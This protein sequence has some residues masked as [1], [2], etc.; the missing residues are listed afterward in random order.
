MKTKQRDYRPV[1]KGLPG[2]LT[3]MWPAC[4]IRS[5]DLPH[6][7]LKKAGLGFW[8]HG[9]SRT[10][11]LTN[12]DQDGAESASMRLGSFVESKCAMH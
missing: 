6:T 12:S 2:R 7:R 11:M 1:S 4:D 5:A 3:P 10:D 8:G 9:L